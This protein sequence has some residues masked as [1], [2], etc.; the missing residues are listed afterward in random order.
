MADYPQGGGH[1]AC[2]LQ[3]FLGLADLGHD[4][5]WLETL[6]LGHQEDAE[7]V[8]DR[9][10]RRMSEFGLADRCTVLV[11]A[12]NEP[13]TFSTGRTFGM[14]AEQARSFCR[15]ADCLWNF[16]G[17]LRYPLLGEFRR[18]AL[19]DGDP[20]EYQVSALQVDMGLDD[21]EVLLTVG[22]RVG[23]PDCVTPT[24]GRTWHTFLPVV[25]L[26]MWPF[27]PD[28]GRS[29]PF[30]SVTHWNW[31]GLVHDG[32][33]VSLSKREAYLRQIDV[34]RLSGRRFVLAANIHPLDDTGDRELLRSSGWD[35]VHPYDV[36]PDPNAYRCFIRGSRAEFCCT[37]PIYR[38]L[39]TG[40]ISDRSAAYLAS[41][42]PVLA[43]DTGFSSR[44][45]VGEGLLGFTS[46][47][48]AVALVAE[49]DGRFQHHS[50]AARELAEQHLDARRQLAAML[51][52]CS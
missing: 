51:S 37:K 32:R 40:W 16:A 36:A 27:A 34:P 33:L 30:T 28:P 45:P 29:A 26:P 2:F 12:P 31:G 20:G 39:G 13:P 50:R 7:P 24:L 43:E 10:F 25:H 52:A 21:H 46:T 23:E 1:W 35:V 18:R 44:L 5:M 42:R 6:K 49:V 15:S 22:S 47:D 14:D 19:I 17:A 9:F 3:F 11:H 4:V 8:L 48:E 41:G 38:E